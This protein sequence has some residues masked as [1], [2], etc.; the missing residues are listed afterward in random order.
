MDLK[1]FI[2]L[3]AVVSAAFA[4]MR[5]GPYFSRQPV[6]T[7]HN[8]DSNVFTVSLFCEARGHPSP[9]VIWRKDGIHLDVDSDSRFIKTADRLTINNPNR[10][11]DSGI[12][13]CVAENTYGSIFSQKAELKF[14]YVERFS[15]APLN[16]VRLEVNTGGCVSCNP[17]DHYPGLD[18]LWHKDGNPI[19]RNERV[20]V[21]ID[22]RLC[23]ANV[24]SSDG[25]EYFCL[26]KPSLDSVGGVANFKASQ[27]FQITT[28]V[29]SA[30]PQSAPSVAVEVPDV[31]VNAGEYVTLEC[32]FNGSPPLTLTWRRKT[33]I[34]EPLPSLS[35][36]SDSNQELVIRG[37]ML[38]DS[39]E[40]ECSASNDLDQD[41]RST[42]TVTVVSSPVWIEKI[43][44]VEIDI[45]ED[46]SWHCEAESDSAI[47]YTWYRNTVEI[48]ADDSRISFS[49]NYRTA[50]FTNLV[51]ED[52]AMYQ[53]VA[54]NEHGEV[55][56]TGQLLVNAIPPSFPIPLQRNQPAARGGS[57][58]IVC[59]PVGAPRP[60]IRWYRQGSQITSGGRFNI[61]E[62]G[63][64]RITD[65][66]DSDAGDYRCEATNTFST[67]SS[68]GSL[69][70]KDGTNIVTPP[71]HTTVTIEED[72]VLI[73]GAS[74]DAE[75]E[76]IY[77]WL[78]KD[79][80]LNIDESSHY[81]KENG[82]LHLL[83]VHQEMQGKYTCRAE[84]SIDADMR[85]VEVIVAGPPDPPTAVDV[86]LSEFLAEITWT[87]GMEHNSPTT[88]F[89]IESKTNHEPNWKEE[90]RV[91]SN[92]D[93]P[94]ATI[95]GLS[96]W[97]TYQFRIAANS[98]LGP[99]QPSVP[100]AEVQ[101]PP[102]GPSV[103]PT[104]VSGGG[105]FQG[106]LRITWEPLEG[107]DQNGPGIYYIV[108]W[109][110]EGSANQFSTAEVRTGENIHIVS[111]VP[112]YTPFEVK[113]QAGNDEGTGPI[114][115]VSIVYS[116]QEAPNDAP[117][118]VQADGM[119]STTLHLQW[120]AVDDSNFE[121]VL[122]GYRIYYWPDGSTQEDANIVEAVGDGTS[123]IVESLEPATKYFVVI[124]ALSLGGEG[125]PSAVQ[126]ASTKKVAPMNA[127]EITEAFVLSG[128]KVRLRWRPI[129]TGSKEEPLDGYH[130]LFWKEGTFIETAEVVEVGKTKTSH[131]I[132]S[133]D[134]KSTYYIRIRGYSKG[135]EGSLSEQK[136]IMTGKPP[137][138]SIEGPGSGGETVTSLV[139]LVG[140]VVLYLTLLLVN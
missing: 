96:P 81:R 33:P 94:R 27:R 111:N 136:E 56:S 98:D 22:G 73:C 92:A 39:G 100:S 67:E 78:F 28:F 55:I 2:I 91:N 63:N 128:N 129:E 70:I 85:D 1:V 122:S 43:S 57:V 11:T 61:T 99:G 82:N 72:T 38:E 60:T 69:V 7:L 58:L 13:Q 109:R 12:Y 62:D 4:L 116:Y 119:S 108:H 105:G 6:D 132:E 59:D 9:T 54:S 51:E 16:D 68:T 46:L 17:P 64:L 8:Q 25:G 32:F 134:P 113:L 131:T 110:Q 139:S 124:E 29:G 83:N 112:V 45:M 52:S 77:I 53:C 36:T 75:F 127:P 34:D 137:T 41:V 65:V 10:D 86:Q 101:T 5:S 42:G 47:T 40:Y 126:T 114:S 130:I 66:Q 120:D 26:V 133:L 74:A 19:S 87:P 84:T 49:D 15:L 37:A 88:G 76:L 21:T 48:Q 3:S 103:S 121:G 71:E 107:K 102:A 89:I 106:D 50:S 104:G 125:P 118:M 79:V 31:T 135:G 30:Q 44:S 123:A 24:E 90:E 138:G 14:A 140:S 115:P 80:Q 117:A 18:V 93:T 95:S 35:S 20:R 97:S 23:F